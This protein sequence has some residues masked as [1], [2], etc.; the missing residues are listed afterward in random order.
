MPVSED[1]DLSPV[2]PNY[3][4]NRTMDQKAY[5]TV[6]LSYRTAIIMH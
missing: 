4:M 6:V 3:S 5:Y 1:F 2:L